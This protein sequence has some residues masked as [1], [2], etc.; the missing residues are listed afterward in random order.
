VRYPGARKIQ[1]AGVRDAEEAA[2]LGECGVGW[3]GFP[4]RLAV[5]E[6]DLDEDGARAIIR[7][8]VP[9]VRAIL[10]TYLAAAPEIVEFSRFLG[11]SAVQ[12]HGE[13]PRRELRRLRSAAPE[14]IVVKSLVVGSR[15]PGELEAAAREFA[16]FV[17]AFLTDTYDPRT[18]ASGATGRSHDWRVS[19]RLVEVSSRPVVLAGGLTPE[20]VGEAVAFVRPAGVDC[21]TGV[22]DASGRKTRDRVGRFVSEA[23]AALAELDRSERN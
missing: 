15:P 21:H 4:L 17:D 10:I 6:A 7:G 9:P 16:P 22:E 1:I 2:L 12:L 18:R 19:R 8:L 14:L 3:I 20:N 11:V 23:D 5:H 13:V